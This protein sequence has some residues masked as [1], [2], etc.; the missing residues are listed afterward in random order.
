M[1]LESK[2]WKMKLKSEIEIKKVRLNEI[3]IKKMKLKLKSEI[4]SIQNY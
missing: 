2:K 3:E 1:K 4:D